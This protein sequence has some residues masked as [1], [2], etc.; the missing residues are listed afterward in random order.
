MSEQKIKYGVYVL[1]K[2]QDHI[3]VKETESY[4]EAFAIWVE[5][6]ERWAMCI[7]E[8]KPFEIVKPIVTAFDPGMIYEVTLRPVPQV[9]A[10]LGNNPYAA[11]AQQQGFGSMFSGQSGILD[12]GYSL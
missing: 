12:G 1:K 6:K 4:D 10:S 8:Q 11:Q 2:S 9:A 7:K 5:L 3:S